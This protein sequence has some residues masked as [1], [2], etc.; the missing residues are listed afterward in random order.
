MP[1][2][3][4]T[5]MGANLFRDLFGGRSGTYEKEL[6]KVRNFTFEQ[7]EETAAKL[8]ANAVRIMYIIKTIFMSPL[9]SFIILFMVK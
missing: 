5:G 2:T 8:G 7:L 4:K 6:K 9:Q 3:D 1:S